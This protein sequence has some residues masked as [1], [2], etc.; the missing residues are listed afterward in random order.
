MLREEDRRLDAEAILLSTMDSVAQRE[1]DYQSQIEGLQEQNRQL[2]STIA[3]L[4]NLLESKD[5]L[6]A[7][8]ESELKEIVEELQNQLSDKM[9]QRRELENLLARSKESEIRTEEQAKDLKEHYYPTWIWPG[10]Y[11]LLPK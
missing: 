7:E 4:N 2:G 11:P 1:R 6:H 10:K 8:R 3:R 5:A 9:L